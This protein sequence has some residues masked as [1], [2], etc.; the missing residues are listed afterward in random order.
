MVDVCCTALCDCNVSDRGRVV[1]LNA[2]TFDM[3]LCIF[4]WKG[5]C[6]DTYVSK[7]YNSMSRRLQAWSS[8]RLDC[9]GGRLLSA[10]YHSSI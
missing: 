3:P 1:G 4:V 5:V 6:R 9:N 8:I 2:G 7:T 10:S